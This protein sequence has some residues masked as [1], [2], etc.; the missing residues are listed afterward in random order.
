MTIDGNYDALQCSTDPF[1]FFCCPPKAGVL[2]KFR[3]NIWVLI[4]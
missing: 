1:Q 3:K 4:E 2:G